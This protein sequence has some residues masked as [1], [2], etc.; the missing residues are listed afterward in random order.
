MASR[1]AIVRISSARMLSRGSR[2][3]SGRLL[4]IRSDGVEAVGRGPGDAASERPLSR[5]ASVEK[6]PALA[7]DSESWASAALQNLH[8]WQ[9]FR[10]DEEFWIN[11]SWVTAGDGC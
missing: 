6:G 7:W 5:W 9:S 2:N 4:P 1:S 10:M 8:R 11:A 3:R